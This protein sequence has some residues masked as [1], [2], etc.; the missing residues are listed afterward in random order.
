VVLRPA[1]LLKRRNA[2]PHPVP[3]RRRDRCFRGGLVSF[4]IDDDW[5]RSGRRPRN[6]FCAAQLPASS[7]S[8][9]DSYIAALF[10]LGAGRERRGSSR[11]SAARQ[12]LGRRR[13]ALAARAATSAIRCGSSGPIGSGIDE[14]PIHGFNPAGDVL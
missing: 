7:I 5:T 13:A 9:L 11:L 6:Q 12:R 4:G 3:L 14:M 8:S 2:K 10:S 1:S